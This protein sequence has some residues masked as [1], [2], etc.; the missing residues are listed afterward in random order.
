[1]KHRIKLWLREAYARL[2][3]HTG[4]HALVN[5]VMPRRLT[6]LF[7]HCVDAPECNRFLPP[8]MK[9]GRENL[10]RILDWFGRR[11]RLA[12]LSEGLDAVRGADGDGRSVVSLTMDD[13]YRD[14]VTTLLPMLQER[15]IGATVFLETRPLDDRRLNWSHKYFWLLSEGRTAEEL[16][17]AVMLRTGDA[18]T[19]E[20]LRRLLEEGADSAYQVKRILKYEAD[21]AERDRVIHTLFEE[22]GGDERSLCDALYMGWDDARALRDGGVELGGHT[23]AHAILSRHDPARQAAEIEGSRESLAREL[24]NPGRVFAYPFGRRWDYD[25]RTLDAAR[26]AGVELAVNTHA[27]TNDARR[28]PL[29]LA[30]IPIDDSAKLHL[31]V[32]EACGGFDLLRRVGLDLSE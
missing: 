17:R 29:Q 23:V 11:Y 14:N 21:E 15:G 12:T 16:A 24:G 32:A 20:K 19:A 30:R 18:E 31:L 26:A 27:G 13:G 2:L 10:V 6:V 1:L 8:D 4:L 9:I 22:A 5:R 28:D 25:Q 3:F 7:G